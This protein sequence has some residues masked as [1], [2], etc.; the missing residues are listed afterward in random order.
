[1]S[2]MRSNIAAVGQYTM[3]GIIGFR[4]AANHGMWAKDRSAVN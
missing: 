1:M 2:I 3:R 4:L